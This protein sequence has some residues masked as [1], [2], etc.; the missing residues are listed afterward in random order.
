MIWWLSVRLFVAMICAVFALHIPLLLNNTLS[1]K[2]T[3][4][5]SEY[6]HRMAL[7]ALI[8][9]PVG[10]WQGGWLSRGGTALLLLSAVTLL[11]PLMQARGI[12]ARLP[13]EMAAAFPDARSAR[14]FPPVQFKGLWTGDR[15]ARKAPPVEHYYVGEGTEGRKLLFHPAAG[16]T[17]APC[18]VVLHGGGWQNGSP[19]EFP[20]WSDYWASEGYAVAALQY[21]LAPKHRWPAPNEDVQ[22]A[23]AWLKANAEKLGIRADAFT[24]LGR[25]A[26]GQIATACAYG[27][28]DPAILG[29][30]S[31]YGPADMVFARR[32][33]FSDDVLNSLGLL[34]NYLGGDPD[35]V[36]ENYAS[37]SGYMLA[38]PE[39]CPTLLIHGTRDIMV[40]N[41]Q[42]RRLAE[43]MKGYGVPHY[44]LEVP[45]GT[46]GLDWPYDTPGGQLTRY[47]VDEFLKTIYVKGPAPL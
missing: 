43:K 1:W 13:T 14:M 5:A 39:S 20:R 16:R 2:L 42:S 12:A 23:L 25:S 11:W 8:I 34:R 24:L 18:I 21:R 26:G 47:A 7:A 41:M 4:V 36:P 10:I 45:W 31:I 30:G 19:A 32:F 3:L 46:H 17:D 33:A 37:A 40:W 15:R 28:H 27:L 35:A 44:L 29:C 9:V 22:L 6:G 38:G